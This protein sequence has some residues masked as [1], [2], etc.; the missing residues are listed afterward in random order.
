MRI[1]VLVA[2]APLFAQTLPR[3]EYPEPRFERP[4]WQSLNGA[5][6]FEFDNANQGVESGWAAGNKELPRKIT[7]PFAPETKRSGIGDTAFHPWVWYRRAFDIPSAWNGKRV[8]LHFGAVDYRA[9]VWVNSQLAGEH[10]GGNTP[11]RF[12]I[13]ALVKPGANTLVVRAEDPPTDRTVPRGKQYWQPKSRGIFYTR[14]TGIWQPV[15]LEATGDAYLD[16]VRADASMEGAARFEARIA[17]YSPDLEFGVSIKDGE[18]VV[19]S[20]TVAADSP[21]TYVDLRVRN[22]RQWYVNQPNLYDVTYEVRRG[23]AVLDSVKSYIGFRTVAVSGGRVLINGRPTYLKMLLDQGYWPE[24]LLTPPSDEAIQFD[25]KASMD[26]GFNGARKHQKL[27]DPRFLY[28]ADKMGFLISDEMANAYEYDADYAERFTR[29]WMEVI[30]RDVSHPSVIMWVP[31]NESWGVPNLADSRQQAHLKAL[32]WLTKSIDPTRPVIDNDGWEHVDTMDLF[33]IHDYTGTGEAFYAK[34][35]D[36]GKPGAPVPNNGRAI[37]VSGYEYNGTPFLLSEFGGIA[38]VPEG[39]R[40]PGDAW[41]YAGTEKTAESAFT[42]LKGLYEAIAKVPAIAG[43]C[44]TQT[45]DV[46]QEVNGL[47]TYD[48]KMKFDPARIKALNDLL[49]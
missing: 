47:M 6:E 27:E 34:Y 40:V 33:T 8:L 41:G 11:F 43:I 14:T 3:P 24:S 32:Y 4:Q 29:E 38:Y 16:R 31:I 1:L 37:L 48:R 17:R 36:L 42:R 19:A 45:T 21:A 39:V 9:S 15:W 18:R 28:W 20:A 25:I 7:V 46:E 49:R 23:G 13:T 10:T 22:P 2:V 12:D 35:K 26:M 30:E 5:W 44:Y